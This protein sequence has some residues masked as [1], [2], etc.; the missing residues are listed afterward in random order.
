MRQIGYR[1]EI[2]ID[3]AQALKKVATLEDLKSL[4]TEY[5]ELVGDAILLVNKMNA[6]DFE[7]FIKNR[8]K[9]NKGIFSNDEI[10]SIIMIPE[11]IMKISM[12]ANQFKVPSGTA[13]IRLKECDKL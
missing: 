11:K 6:Q 5:D 7:T 1:D 13:Y 9:E 10:T 8:N 3:Y 2:D 4:M 12:T